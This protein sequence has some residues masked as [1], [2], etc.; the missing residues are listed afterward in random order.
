MSRAEAASFGGEASDIPA[1]Y[2]TGEFGVAEFAR[3]RQQDGRLRLTLNRKVSPDGSYSGGRWIP[4]IPNSF[5]LPPGET[6]PGKTDFCK[7][8]YAF[9]NMRSKGVKEALDK[10]YELLKSLETADEMTAY[11]VEMVS[12]YQAFASKNDVSDKNMVF[13]IHWSGDFYSLDYARAWANTVRQFPDILFWAYTRSFRPPVD[14]VPVLDGIDNLVLLLSTDEYNVDEIPAAYSHLA[15]ANSAL[16]VVSANQ[17][18]RSDHK[19]MPCPENLNRYDL[20]QDGEGACIHCR[21]CFRPPIEQVVDITFVT[22]GKH[23]VLPPKAY[24]Q[25]VKEAPIQAGPK[26]TIDRS[27][28]ITRQATEA[29]E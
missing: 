27:R 14:A 18:A 26:P 13:R 9:E 3:G 10:N 2:E 6:C 7:S 4:T 12:R 29:A 23:K 15:R 21:A 25:K 5:G 19:T 22:S 20:M 28:Y 16:D 24:G 1:A 17:F 8:C 11:L